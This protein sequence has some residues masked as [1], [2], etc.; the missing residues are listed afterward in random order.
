LVAI[1]VTLIIMIGLYIIDPTTITI[2]HTAE[3]I[4]HNTNIVTETISNT[5][6]SHLKQELVENNPVMTEF[7]P[8]AIPKD[9]N[10][11]SFAET[12]KSMNAVM[13]S[14]TNFEKEER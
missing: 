10:D 4:N 8:E 14:F 2:R 1:T 9:P 12:M 5:V 7:N 13:S 6:S 11:V 3:V